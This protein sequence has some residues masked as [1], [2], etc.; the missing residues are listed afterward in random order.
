MASSPSSSSSSSEI[1]QKI[2]NEFARLYEKYGSPPVYTLPELE[3][4][5]DEER[6]RKV[7]ESLEIYG[8]FFIDY[9]SQDIYEYNLEVISLELYRV[10]F[11]DLDEAD[12]EEY[13]QELARITKKYKFSC[14][15]EYK[16]VALS[17]YWNS[18]HGFGNASFRFFYMQFLENDPT[19]KIDGIDKEIEFNYNPIHRH[20][21][22]LLQMCPQF[23]ELMKSLYDTNVMVSWDS[24]KVR[25]FDTGRGQGPEKSTRPTLT[26]R[27]H[28]IYTYGGKALDRLQSMLIMQHDNAIALG[29]VPFSHRSRVRRYISSLLGGEKSMFGLVEHE[30]LN[31]ILDRYW[32]AP[33]N[34]FVIWKQETVHF[35]GVPKSKGYLRRIS[36]EKE[37]DHLSYL[38]FR[39][40]IGVHT[41]Q[42]LGREALRELCYLSEYGFLPEI[43]KNKKSGKDTPISYNLVNAKSTRYMIPREMTSIE[44]RI[45]KYLRK[46]YN[47]E[48]IDETVKSLPVIIREMYGIYE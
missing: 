1:C 4:C 48:E 44:K 16:V 15:D 47:R 32:R 21:L 38:S 10:I 35:E 18:K 46:H 7:E 33:K 34:G 19:F 2:E 40:V 29:F 43:Y 37:V 12:N 3:E 41:P 22:R 42:E 20:N 36:D 17:S 8:V 27:H 24:Q 23:W 6:K 30:E 14:K 5:D 13:R 9:Y 45:L 26:Q 11:G 31:G 25:F 28:D 39:A